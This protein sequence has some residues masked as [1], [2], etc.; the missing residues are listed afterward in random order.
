M[1]EESD[2]ATHFYGFSG[3][4]R[5]NEAVELACAFAAAQCPRDEIIAALERSPIAA[6]W[7]EGIAEEVYDYAKADL[8]NA[9][10]AA[11][12]G[13]RVEILQLTGSVK[14]CA[15]KVALLKE[16]AY[17]HLDWSRE[18]IDAEIKRELKNAE[19]ALRDGN[20]Q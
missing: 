12:A 5:L 4:A 6:D 15:A 14:I 1:L 7:P 17:Q 16:W 8:Y 9:A 13:V 20:V 11:R 3:Q 19:K 18:P 2:L 10:L